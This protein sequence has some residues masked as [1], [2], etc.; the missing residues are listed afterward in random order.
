[1]GFKGILKGRE[2][3]LEK[4]MGEGRG[5]RERGGGG[6][7]ESFAFPKKQRDY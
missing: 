7:W 5:V 6:A 2:R 1:M 4:A 3:K